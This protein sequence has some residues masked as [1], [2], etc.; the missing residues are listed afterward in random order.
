MLHKKSGILSLVGWLIGFYFSLLKGRRE[1]SRTMF[2]LCTH[3]RIN[4]VYIYVYI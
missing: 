4:I 3:T 2:S 1:K